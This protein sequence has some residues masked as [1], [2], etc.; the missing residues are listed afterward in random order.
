MDQK[1][2]EDA[3][4][5]LV[6]FAAFASSHVRQCSWGSTRRGPC[7]T[8]RLSPSQYG[9]QQACCFISSSVSTGFFIGI[10]QMLSTVHPFTFV[11][12]LRATSSYKKINVGVQIRPPVH[13]QQYLFLRGAKDSRP[14][15]CS[16]ACTIKSLMNGI[17]FQ[18]KNGNMSQNVCSVMHK[19]IQLNRHPWVH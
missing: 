4:L 14:H 18:M 10:F 16:D 8:S 2:A 5:T 3:E 1:L 6:A 19:R 11:R 9:S 13:S 7:L 15:F 17:I 12:E